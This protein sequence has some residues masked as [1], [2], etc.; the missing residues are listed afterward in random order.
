M[1]IYILLM[2]IKVKCLYIT[3][4]IFNINLFMVE[5]DPKPQMCGRHPKA[6][7]DAFCQEKCCRKP[8]CLICVREGHKTHNSKHITEIA[9][10]MKTK[11]PVFDYFETP[12]TF[13]HAQKTFMFTIKQ[14]KDYY[15]KIQK[16]M[17]QLLT[18][19]IER[20]VELE[21]LFDRIGNEQRAKMSD[22][23]G[24][25]LA[26]AIDQAINIFNY[27]KIYKMMRERDLETYGIAQISAHGEF[28]SLMNHRFELIKKC[29]DEIN[30][31]LHRND[32]LDIK[33]L[34]GV[35]YTNYGGSKDYDRNINLAYIENKQLKVYNTVSK[36][37][38]TMEVCIPNTSPEIIEIEGR[39]YVIGDSDFQPSI[40][41][42]NIRTGIVC[43]KADMKYPKY[44]THLIHLKGFIYSIGMWNP[45]WKADKNCEKYEI[46]SNKW[47]QIPP[48]HSPKRLVG[49][50]A[51]NN[52]YVYIFGGHNESNPVDE[53]EYLD[54]EKE[55][56]G[57][58]LVNLTAEEKSSW[59][60]RYRIASAQATDEEILLFGGYS[61]KNNSECYLFNPI[62]REMKKIADLKQPAQFNYSRSNTCVC[63][64]G[65]IKAIDINNRIQ[66]YDVSA[67]QWEVVNFPHNC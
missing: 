64:D 41:E 61:N 46:E 27:S 63:R 24:K 4:Y 56:E 34:E 28:K 57:W 7:A 1:I 14:T 59:S 55:L 37:G 2:D 49:G 32:E 26:A 19:K 25:E 42:I 35:K 30:I 23:K 18:R 13:A 47:I 62:K 16:I 17:H 48:L 44:Q 58:K 10:D 12:E 51:F 60:P 53:I 66:T 11:L 6:R 52:R 20:L 29:M 33:Q 15:I 39:I 54:S 21:K 50:C 3:L 40:Y 67:D 45:N 31:L 5:G 8:I 43:K 38:K 36:S 9:E 22:E 65:K